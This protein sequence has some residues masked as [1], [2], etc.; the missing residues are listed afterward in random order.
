MRFEEL[1]LFITVA[2]YENIR[3]A[4]KVS[5]LSPASLSRA[6][7]RLEQQFGVTLFENVGRSIE[8]NAKGKRLQKKAQELLDQAQSLKY[9]ISNALDSQELRISGRSTLHSQ[10]S[11]KLASRWSKQLPSTMT[12]FYDTSDLEAFKAV[13]DGDAHFCITT[14][15]PPAGYATVPLGTFKMQTCAGKTHPIVSQL[16]DGTIAINKLLQHDFVTPDILLFGKS[17]SGYS[18]DGWR[19]DLFPRKIRYIT[20]S[21]STMESIICSGDALGYLAEFRVTALP[22]TVLTIS[23]CDFE[24]EHAVYF[25]KKKSRQLSYVQDAFDA[26]FD[27]RLLK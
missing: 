13:E 19:D 18:K 5:G 3:M 11:T 22:V 20:R 7:A 6:M 25:S 8:L 24:C 2:E 27:G 17:T 16:K 1:Q 12:R 21:L 23:G 9:E 10:F 4:A 15:K 26:I 14:K